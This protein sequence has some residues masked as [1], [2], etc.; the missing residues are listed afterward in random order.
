MDNFVGYFGLLAYGFLILSELII[1]NEYP[2][3]MNICL[4]N[5]IMSIVLMKLNH[6]FN[7]P[8]ISFDLPKDFRL[9]MKRRP[10]II[11]GAH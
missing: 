11:L 1:Y 4:P 10:P 6:V 8:E 5:Q 7:S 9:N 3:D 2:Y